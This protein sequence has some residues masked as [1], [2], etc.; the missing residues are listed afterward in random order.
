MHIGVLRSWIAYKVISL[1]FLSCKLC[2]KLFML[3]QLTENVP[4]ERPDRLD[5]S[6]TNVKYNPTNS[7]LFNVIVK[8]GTGN[9]TW[10]SKIL[11]MFAQLKAV[12]RNLKRN[13]I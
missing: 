11:S 9:L 7:M 1:C 8:Y 3:Y 10:L 6:V 4:G 13:F 5:L 2:E 12:K